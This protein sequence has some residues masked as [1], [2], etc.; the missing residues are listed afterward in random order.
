MWHTL[1]VGIA[2]WA[3][4]AP[5]TE[6]ERPACDAALRGQLWPLEANRDPKLA[7]RLAREG[8]LE[9]CNRGPWRYRWTSPSVHIRQLMERAPKEKRDRF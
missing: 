5:A 3:G 1:A 9:I 4:P 2:L 7:N 6:A 8:R